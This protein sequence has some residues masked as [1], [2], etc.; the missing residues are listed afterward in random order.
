MVVLN[1][2]AFVAAL[3]VCACTAQRPFYASSNPYPPVLPQNMPNNNGG[4]GNR[5]GESSATNPST[6]INPVYNVEQELVD[7]VKDYPRDKQPFWYL[8]AAQLNS[9]KNPQQQQQPSQQQPSQQ[10]QPQ[11]QQPQQQLEQRFQSSQQPSQQLDQQDL[12][13]QV[14]KLQR[15]QQVLKQQV[16]E[17]LSQQ[18]L[19]IEI[20][21]LLK[22]TRE[23]MDKQQTRGRKF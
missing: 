4:L 10:Q 23:Q 19:K 21:K 15:E 8:N 14:Q 16:E 1:E 11:Q 9:F 20:E 22:D 5:L 7:R 6:V 2:A 17:M 12:M 3:F 18:R 13:L